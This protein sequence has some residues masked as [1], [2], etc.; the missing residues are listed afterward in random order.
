MKHLFSCMLVVCNVS[1][2]SAQTLD[3]NLTATSSHAAFAPTAAALAVEAPPS[4]KAAAK[5]T[6]SLS[7]RKSYFRIGERVLAL[8]RQVTDNES[9]FVLLSLH[10]NESNVSGTARKY[11]YEN[12][13]EFFELLN[14][15]QREIAFTL[16]EKQMNV[17]PNCIFTPKGR[18]Q[19]LSIN[20]KT[21]VVISHQINGLAQFILNELPFEKA[22]VSLHGNAAGEYTIDDYKKGG[23][24]QRDAWMLH[25][26]PEK[27]ATDFFVTTS[28]PVFD[29]LKQKNYNVVLQ[30]AR[31]SDDGSLAV[32]CGRTRRTY[33][34]IETAQSNSASQEEMIRT[35]AGLFQ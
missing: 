10:N 25:R 1:L 29:L 24:R 34:G 5:K 26:N 32:F 6:F 4:E 21:D 18:N 17:D 30:S 15:G 20:R 3:N 14:D 28:R 7:Q 33:I 2:L 8:Q 11:I 13:G 35:V 22:L 27:P 9:P 23:Q 19:D 12:G 31:C 16:F